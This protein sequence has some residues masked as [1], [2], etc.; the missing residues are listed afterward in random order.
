MGE[1]TTV[2]QTQSHQSVLRLDQR[3]QSCKAKDNW[4]VPSDRIM[5]RHNTLGGLAEKIRPSA[6]YD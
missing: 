1:M 5:K 3:R 6:L 2:R 4:S